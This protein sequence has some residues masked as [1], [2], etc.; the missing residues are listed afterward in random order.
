VKLLEQVRQ[1]LHIKHYSYRTELCYLRRIEQEHLP[2]QDGRGLSSFRP[3]RRRR[4]PLSRRGRVN[5]CQDVTGGP[6]KKGGGVA[7]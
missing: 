4:S 6:P 7:D 1:A 2:P 3:A 5:S